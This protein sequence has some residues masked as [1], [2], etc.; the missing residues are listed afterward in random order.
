MQPVSRQGIGQH[1]SI[2]TELL[3]EMVFST[4]SVQCGYK[5]ENWGNQFSCEMM[6]SQQWHEGVKLKNFHS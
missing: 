1:A 6:A 3:L 5:V 2:T 4:R